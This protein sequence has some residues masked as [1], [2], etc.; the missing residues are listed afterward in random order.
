MSVPFAKIVSKT[1]C[2]MFAQTAGVDFHSVLFDLNTIEKT[3]IIWVRAPQRLNRFIDPLMLLNM[4]HLVKNS[5]ILP[6]KS[7]DT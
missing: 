7:D 4:Q 6:Q 2:L 5:E 3:I 1:Y